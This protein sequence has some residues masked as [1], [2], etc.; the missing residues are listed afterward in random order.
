[1]KKVKIIFVS[2]V[3]LITPFFYQ[4]QKG[5]IDKTETPKDYL[6]NDYIV[7]LETLSGFY[8]VAIQNTKLK[9]SLKNSELIISEIEN[10]VAK[11]CSE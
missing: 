1:M 5:D 3:M 9:S 7:D 6:S 10:Q 11:K 8:S 4:C 2:V